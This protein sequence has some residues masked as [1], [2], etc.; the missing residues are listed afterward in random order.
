M[1]AAVNR[2]DEALTVSRA[3][4]GEYKGGLDK[5]LDGSVEY[6]SICASV[7]AARRSLS[8][9]NLLQAMYAV[10]SGSP[11]EKKVKVEGALKK[12]QAQCGDTLNNRLQFA[13]GELAK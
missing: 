5:W 3:S 11:A 7:K 2:Y 4:V 8:I 9:C 13:A 12:A 6:K 10:M 1:L